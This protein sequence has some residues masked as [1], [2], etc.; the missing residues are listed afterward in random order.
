[1]H[2]PLTFLPEKLQLFISKLRKKRI[3]PKIIFISLGILS[4]IWFAIRV[5]P[6]PSRATYPC[7]QATA[8]CMSSFVVWLI[9]VWGGLFSLKQWRFYLGKSNY[10]LAGLFMMISISSYLMVQYANPLPAGAKAFDYDTRYFVPN[11]PIGEAQGIFP[12][13]VVWYWDADATNENCT[14][15]SNNNGIIDQGDDAWFMA[16]NNK[17][18]VINNMVYESLQLLTGEE[19]PADCW[20]AIFRYYNL[21]HGNGDIGYSTGEKIF[22]KVNATTAFGGS[23]GGRYDEELKRNDDQQVN[24]FAAETNPY[25]V[26][27]LLNQLVDHGGVPEDMIYVGDPARNIYKEFYDLWKDQYPGIHILG[28]NLIHN[29]LEITELGRFAVAH[30]EEYKIFYSDNGQVMEDAVSDKLFSIFEEVDYL[31]NIPAMKAHASAGITL[32]AKNHFG[33]LPRNWAMHVHPGLL[34]I[35]DDEPDRLGYGLYRIQTDIMMHKLLSGKYLLMIVDG[36]YPGEG[37]LDTPDKWTMPPFGGYWASSLFFSFDPVAIEAVCH[38][39]LRSEYHGDTYAENR[40]NWNGV[41]DY[42]LQAADSSLWPEG[43]IYDPDGDEQLIASLGVHEHW[44]D[45]SNKEYTRNLGTGD[46]IELIRGH[47][48]SIGREEIGIQIEMNIYP[49]PSSGNVQL[50]LENRQEQIGKLSVIN[51]IG[52]M[53]YEIDNPFGERHSLKLDFTGYGNGVYFIMME[54]PYTRFTKKLVVEQ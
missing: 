46:G 1:M 16:E 2:D 34:S 36:L 39:F 19:Q 10:A 22:I 41:D 30:T 20:D 32:A 50:E 24:N 6:K 25:V 5:I 37:A 43:V 42:L 17:Q 8:P 4:T 45:S 7:M 11:D 54:T 35:Y 29:E 9:G 51:S 47:D 21:N 52:K 3:H 27:S 33:S 31:I 48:N 44:N 28:N 23:E 49:N 14:N 13:R 15:T 12:G 26:L 38:D 53:I 40:P 18:A